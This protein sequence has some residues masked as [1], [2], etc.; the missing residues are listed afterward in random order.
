MK[1]KSTL[2]RTLLP[3]F[4]TAITLG[5]TTGN[6]LAHDD[7][8]NDDHYDHS[9]APHE[10]PHKAEPRTGGH[11]SLAAVATNPIA[12]LVQF[13]LQDQYNWDNHKSSG[14]SNQFLIQPVAPFKLPSKA[15]PLL[16]TRTTL[17]Y[18]STPDLGS[19]EHRKH[20]LGDTT[21]LALGL[22]KISLEK[23]MIGVGISSVL[24]TGGGNDA[25]GSGKWQLGP[26]LVYFNQQIPKLQ[27]GRWV[28]TPSRLAKP[29]RVRT[30]RT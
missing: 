10:T 27:W 17:P 2:L 18:V 19:P 28:G 20:G 26:A 29:V 3:V 11:A 5:L 1:A 4:S 6:A 15:V 8:G 30:R 14:Y 23:Q 12:N 7:K 13:Q 24:P 22:P 9:G 25:T 21:F 16:I